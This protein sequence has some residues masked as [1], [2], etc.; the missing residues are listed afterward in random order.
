MRWWP[1]GGA[2]QCALAFAWLRSARQRRRWQPQ[3]V[4]CDSWYPSHKRLQR[5]RAEGGDCVCQRKKQ[6]RCEGR[7][8]MRALQHPSWQATGSLA[9]D[10]KGC[11]VRY[12]GTDSAPKR[13]SLTATEGRP[14]SRKGQERDE[15][16]RV[17][18]RQWSLEA[19]QAGSRRSSAAKPRGREGAHEHHSA[20]CLVASRMVERARLDRG[21][22]WRQRQRP[23][24]RTGPP[25]AS[26]ALRRVQE[27]A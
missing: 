21:A 8:L 12:G 22:T 20:L 24:I 5:L 4:L 26:P 3:G 19:C 2:A 27:A 18:Q 14:L 16:I 1:Q 10:I 25:H 17:V 23:L 6:R 7:P 15:G 9:G 13:F 11:G